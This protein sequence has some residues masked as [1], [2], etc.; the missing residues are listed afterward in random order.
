MSKFSSF[1]EDNSGGLS[2]IRLCLFAWVFGVLAIW[3]FMS[4]KAAELQKLD[5]SVVT[6]IGSLAAV[7]G[8]QR[9]GEQTDN[10]TPTS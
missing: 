4:F 6:V 7:K 10:S 5:T 8:V 3:I 2:M 9:F 1:F